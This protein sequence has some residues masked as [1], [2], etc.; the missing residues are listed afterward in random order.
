MIDY[1]ALALGHGLLATAIIRLLMR[2]SLDVDPELASL[3]EQAAAKREAKRQSRSNARRQAQA[4]TRA[5][6]AAEP[7]STNGKDAS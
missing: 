4:Q 3:Q 2:D 1:F 7:S 5:L 6:A